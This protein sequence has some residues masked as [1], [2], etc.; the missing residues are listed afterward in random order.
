MSPAR[1]GPSPSCR[2][3]RIRLRSSSRSWTMRCRADCSS[4]ESP[5]ACTAAATCGTRSTIRRWSRSRSRSPGVVRAGAR[6]RRCP[7]GRAERRGRRR[8]ACRTRRRPLAAPVARRLRG[9]PDVLQGERPADRLDDGGKHGVRLQRACE[10]PAEP[11]DRGV[12]IVPLAVHQPIDEALHALPQRLEADG[13]DAGYD[14]RDDEVAAGRE[15]RAD[16]SDDGDIAA[17]DADG[18]HA[19]YERAIDDEVDL[20]EPVLENGNG[21]ACGQREKRQHGQDLCAWDDAPQ[22][23][24]DDKERHGE[25]E[26]HAHPA[27]LLALVTVGPSVAHYE[28]HERR[29][30]PANDE[31]RSDNAGRDHRRGCQARADSRSA[32]PHRARTS[33]KPRQQPT[34]APSPP[35]RRPEPATPD[36][37][38]GGRPA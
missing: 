30:E 13:D 31:D 6:R 5:T 17:D 18:Q 29:A 21:D 26:R 4:C 8:P 11:G 36:A 2:S 15:R 24:A 16:Q 10:R 35:Q 1:A 20:V 23:G 19:V 25:A 3:R 9:E 12:W 32:R 34:R 33:E 14:E 37:M 22:Q 7:G 27:K 28:C 38:P